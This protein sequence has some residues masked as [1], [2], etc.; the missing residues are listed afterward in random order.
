[1]IGKFFTAAVL[2]TSFAMAYSSPTAAQG[3]VGDCVKKEGVEKARCERHQKMAEKCGALKGE[4]HHVCDREFLIANPL[5][6]KA[7]SGKSAIACEAEVK[8]FKTCEPKAG[9]E[10]MKCVKTTTGE[11]PM[12]H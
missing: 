12:G 6:C 9:V 11:S 4:A 5:D 2:A 7:Q 8:A 1:M 3:H 10:F